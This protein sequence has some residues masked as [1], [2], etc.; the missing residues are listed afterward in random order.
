MHALP[1]TAQLA[2]QVEACF[3]HSVLHAMSGGRVACSGTLLGGGGAVLAYPQLLFDIA[4]FATKPG[5][6]AMGGVDQGLHNYILHWLAPRRPDLLRFDVLVLANDQSPI[7]TSGVRAA[8]PGGRQRQPGGAH[9]ARAHPPPCCTRWTATPTWCSTWRRCPWTSCGACKRKCLH[10]LLPGVH[11]FGRGSWPFVRYA[12]WATF[13]NQLR[14]C[15]CMSCQAH[16]TKCSWKSSTS[17][18]LL[19]KHWPVLLLFTPS[20]RAGSCCKAGL[21]CILIGRL[22]R[23]FYD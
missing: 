2:R 4:N 11:E 5:C 15:G 10:V 20:P 16:P 6:L 18:D 1:L 23:L 8:A 17:D 22:N 21:L 13:L 19:C 3:N 9:P 12:L 14:A 7:Y